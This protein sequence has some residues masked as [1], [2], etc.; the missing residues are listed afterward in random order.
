MSMFSSTKRSILGP[1]T[2][3]QRRKHQWNR[4]K[5]KS[6]LDWKIKSLPESMEKTAWGRKTTGRSTRSGR[7]R[8]NPAEGGSWRPP[9]LQGGGGGAGTCGG[10]RG[11]RKLLL[12]PSVPLY[13]VELARPEIPVQTWTKNSDANRK[14]R[15]RFGPEILGACCPETSSFPKTCV[16][17]RTRIFR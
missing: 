9:E 13:R 4:G 3:K 5:S 15:S 11:S 10:G 7:G 16:Q 2:T 17:D 14:F 12:T 8:G 6:T 1:H